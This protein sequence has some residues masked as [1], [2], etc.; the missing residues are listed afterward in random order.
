MSTKIKKF[1]D[2][3]PEKIKFIS[4]SGR[5]NLDSLKFE[6]PAIDNTQS[7]IQ[8]YKT[9]LE[10]IYNTSPDPLILEHN[11]K[12][13]EIQKWYV[14]SMNY[15]ALEQNNIEVCELEIKFDKLDELGTIH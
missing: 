6:Y 1:L 14:T 9:C 15:G 5:N 3:K 7:S 11:N 4:I 12:I 13:F 2:I 8:F 10:D